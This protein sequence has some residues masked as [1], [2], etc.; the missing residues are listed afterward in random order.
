MWRSFPVP[1]P[2]GSLEEPLEIIGS[3]CYGSTVS[4][5]KMGNQTGLEALE[6]AAAILFR[7]RP[8]PQGTAACCGTL[9][10]SYAHH[11]AAWVAF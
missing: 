6:R 7:V 5:G 3:H 11:P 8:S 4:I 9:S 2:R 10:Y 1:L